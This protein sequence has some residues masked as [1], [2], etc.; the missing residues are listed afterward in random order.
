MSVVNMS[1][2]NA[3]FRMDQSVR[4]FL[5]PIQDGSW[6]DPSTWD[7]GQVPG[8]GDTVI[9]D[10]GHFVDIISGG[11][12]PISSLTIRSGAILGQLTRDLEVTGDYTVNGL[13]IITANQLALTGQGAV[14]TGSGKIEFSG[15]DDQARVEIVGRKVIPDT[16]KLIVFGPG[17]NGGIRVTGIIDNFGDF[18][19][20]ASL[21]GT[22]T[23][24][25]HPFSRL[26]VFTSDFQLGLDASM[27]NNTV[28]YQD[29]IDQDIV[30]PINGLF[31]NLVIGGAGVKKLTSDI[32]VANNLFI[33][34]TMDVDSINN[35]TI[36]LRNTW[37]SRLGTFIERQGTVIMTGSTEQPIIGGQGIE[38]FYNLVIDNPG[39]GVLLAND[40]I[41]R[42]RLS[43]LQGN[44]AIPASAKLTLGTGLDNIGFLE[45]VD[46]VVFGEMERW[47]NDA[48]DGVFFPIGNFPSNTSFEFRSD[49][50]SLGSLS[51]RFNGNDPGNLGAPWSGWNTG[52]V[53]ADV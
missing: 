33:D 8:E 31:Y 53:S 26:R 51:V 47:I 39:I 48:R 22:G 41:V 10:T 6:T 4:H 36:E 38:T 11:S 27:E 32:I 21:T 24:V 23:W 30:N 5:Y 28:L 20:A 45:Y 1:M 13:H 17:I 44:I 16:A 42:N 52:F 49:N 18:E 40:V 29:I 7:V 12:P 9:I 34:G 46:G 19:V 14:F 35:Y 50:H 43:M 15:I 2:A 37:D 3:I 25:N